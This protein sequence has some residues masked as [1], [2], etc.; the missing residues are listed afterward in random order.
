MR[1]LLTSGYAAEVEN[2]SQGGTNFGVVAQWQ[3]ASYNDMIAAVRATGALNPC[4]VGGN[5]YMGQ[6]SYWETATPTD[7][8]NQI[9][10]EWHAYPNASTYANETAN[11]FP[12]DG[13]TATDAGTVANYNP[14]NAL[15]AAGKCIF[16]TEFGGWGG[17]SCTNGE[18]AMTNLLNWIFAQTHPVSNAAWQYNAYRA[19][20]TTSEQFYL[21]VYNSGSS[22]A[23]SPILGCGTV[24]KPRMLARA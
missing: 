2:Q 23:Y 17:T 12:S 14:A 21:N 9:F 24:L 18:P 20:G 22:G 1:A 4:G 7:S 10:Y 11:P 5:N 8:T 19:S 16:I 3:T 13:T 15:L 6:L